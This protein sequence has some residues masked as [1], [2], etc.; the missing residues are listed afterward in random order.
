MLACLA[1][2]VAYALPLLWVHALSIAIAWL[3]QGLLVAAL[4]PLLGE[5]YGLR[6]LGMLVGLTALGQHLS[7]VLGAWLGAYGA[8][9]PASEQLLVLS[10]AV[11]FLGATVLSRAIPARRDAG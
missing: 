4:V 10:T 7:S 8:A 5:I 11:A 1:R 6:H 3:L 9:G 2:A